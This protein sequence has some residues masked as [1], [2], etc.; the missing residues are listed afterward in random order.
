[1]LLASFNTRLQMAGF[2]EYTL[3]AVHFPSSIH[4]NKHLTH[5]KGKNGIILTLVVE[6]MDVKGQY[7]RSTRH[8]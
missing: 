8:T 4:N 2:K 3:V 1:M 6:R 7:I 5:S